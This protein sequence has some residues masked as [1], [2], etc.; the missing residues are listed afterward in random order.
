MNE[1]TLS[2]EM[3]GQAL[4]E[5]RFTDAAQLLQA[6]VEQHPDDTDAWFN[7]GFCLRQ[8]LQPAAA[9]HAYQR[10]ID[11][12]ITEPEQAHLNM[13]AVKAEVFHDVAGARASLNTAL[14]LQPAFVLAWQNLGQL[15]EDVGNADAA[16]AA[17]ESALR[18]APGLGRA[19]ARI[20]GI[21]VFSGHAAE[22]LARVEQ[23]AALATTHDDLIELSFSA[24][25]ALDALGRYDE[26]F[27]HALD[28]NQLQKQSTRLA[29]RQS[30]VTA[31]IDAMIAL[32]PEEPLPA[33]EMTASPI[34]ICGL[35]RSGST[36]LETLLNRHAG[37]T[38]GG[39]LAYT[40]W[41]MTQY[42]GD[43]QPAT[44]ADAA[45]RFRAEYAS[46][47]QG[48]LGGTSVFTDKRM[49]NFL[50]LGLIKRA[51]PAAKIVHVMRNP[52]DNF[53]SMYF[54]PFADNLTYANDFDDM[55]HYYRQYRRLMAHWQVCFGEDIIP[56][57]YEA[58]V[59][60]P[61]A[62]IADIAQA[63][64]LSGKA[65]QSDAQIIRTASVW[66]V[67]QP[68]HAR[69]RG[70]WRNYAAH[71]GELADLLRAEYPEFSE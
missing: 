25:N 17:Y 65:E 8:M 67:R 62:V 29:H 7:L 50:Y 59:E 45:A 68:V 18:H 56:V 37:V 21:E 47:A 16:R 34:F 15:E 39:E 30:D 20:A 13:A 66:Q 49:D 41:F 40:P 43:I 27:S 46:F 6:W 19:H 9:L 70:R 36:L 42:G 5:H 57:R 52:I 71:V 2:P 53:L 11:A 38:M 31:Q 64:G 22:G 58:L 51:F 32:F 44:V 63:V 14:S 35:F 60:Q 3:I 69:S 24:A 12:G 23:A 1:P 33:A 61:E 54:L 4:T 10:A 28:A 48:V 55:L 26:A